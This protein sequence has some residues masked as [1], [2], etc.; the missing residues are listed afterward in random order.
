MYSGIVSGTSVHDLYTVP[1]GKRLILKFVTVQEVTGSSCDAQLRLGSF[2]TIF[3]WNLL[4]YGSAGSRGVGS[5]WIVLP[6]GEVVQF[7]RT[8]SGD[9]TV[10]V[11]GS[12]HTI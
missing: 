6:P 1:S 2:G 3:V 7:K 9:I 8:T 12:L 4:A 10:T 11:S 5:F